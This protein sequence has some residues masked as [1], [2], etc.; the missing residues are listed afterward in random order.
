MLPDRQLRVI[1]DG[2]ELIVHHVITDT[3]TL[4]PIHSGGRAST[5]EVSVGIQDKDPLCG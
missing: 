4:N 1:D 3:I 2:A 5:R